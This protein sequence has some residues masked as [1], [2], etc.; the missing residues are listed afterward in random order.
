MRTTLSEMGPAIMLGGL[1]TLLGLLPLA[2]ATT[3]LFYVFFTLM[4][5]TI[6]IALAVGLL[7]IPALMG[8][9]GPAAVPQRSSR[10]ASEL[11]PGAAEPP[12]LVAP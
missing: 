7:L 4:V 10:I 6:G 3:D 11:A 5:S 8:T 1:S 2:G 12:V 9:I